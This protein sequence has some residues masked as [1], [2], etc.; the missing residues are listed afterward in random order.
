MSSL[1]SAPTWPNGAGSQW[2][3]AAAYKVG[4]APLVPLPQPCLISGSPVLRS[5][6]IK[7]HDMSHHQHADAIPTHATPADDDSHLPRIET[8]HSD[9]V[10][11]NEADQSHGVTGKAGKLLTSTAPKDGDLGAR[12]LATYDGPRPELTDENNSHVRNKID[13]YL[14]PV[15]FLIYFNQ[16]QVSVAKP[17]AS[18]ARKRP[19]W[20][21]VAD[22]SRT[23]PA[24][25]S[26]LSLASVTMRT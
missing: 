11:F 13:S 22:V 20:W 5:I 26:L 14:L 8:T 1:A 17:C 12:W 24:S 25:L 16:Q 18:S 23:S 19:V 9:N 15:I 4:R 6:T 10:T 7:P 21:V 2:K 3:C